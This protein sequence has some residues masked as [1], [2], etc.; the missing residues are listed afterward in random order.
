MW[1]EETLHTLLPTQTKR[2]SHHLCLILMHISSIQLQTHHHFLSASLTHILLLIHPIC[3]THTQIVSRCLLW[4]GQVH[5]QQQGD[6]FNLGA[7]IWLTHS[8]RWLRLG[9]LELLRAVTMIDRRG[10]LQ[11]IKVPREVIFFV[12]FLEV[13]LN[14]PLWD[15]S[16]PKSLY[17]IHLKDVNSSCW[18]LLNQGIWNR[19]VPSYFF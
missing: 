7:I 6:I 9:E 14:L 15:Y 3:S 12:H 16:R 17:C 8:S 19:K 2:V 11:Y 10:A 13:T 1:S 4:P 18:E 5:E